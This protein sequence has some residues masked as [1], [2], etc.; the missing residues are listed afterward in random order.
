MQDRASDLA[1]AVMILADNGAAAV[2][3]LRRISANH[4]LVRAVIR[5]NSSAARDPTELALLARIDHH[6]PLAAATRQAATGHEQ[7]LLSTDDIVVEAS[8]PGFAPVQVTIKT[9]TDQKDSV[10]AIAEASAGKPVDFMGHSA[11]PSLPLMP[12]A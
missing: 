11:P 5:V 7:R 6:G 2:C 10:M 3:V 4:G 12:S 1:H 9:S 8:S